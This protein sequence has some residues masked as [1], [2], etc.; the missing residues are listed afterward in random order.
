MA[1]VSTPAIVA[2]ANNTDANHDRVLLNP[3]ASITEVTEALGYFV[4]ENCQKD[5]PAQP[6]R[7]EEAGSDGNAIEEGVDHQAKQHR[8][9]P[10]RMQI[11]VGV[12]L[13]PI[14]KMRGDGVLEKMHQQIAEHKK[15]DSV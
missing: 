4:Q 13:F 5:D 9:A 10:V 7:N 3:L 1:M 8:H 15:Q 2:S 6:G 11:L 12:G 14:M